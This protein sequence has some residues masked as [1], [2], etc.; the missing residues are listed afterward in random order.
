LFICPLLGVKWLENRR[1]EVCTTPPLFVGL[2]EGL[3]DKL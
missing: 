3:I 2:L 1:G